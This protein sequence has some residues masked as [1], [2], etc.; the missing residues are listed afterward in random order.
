MDSRPDEARCELPDI[1][2]PCQQPVT[3]GLRAA[4]DIVKWSKRRSGE[5]KFRNTSR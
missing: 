1:F 5:D 4:T 2:E 3:V